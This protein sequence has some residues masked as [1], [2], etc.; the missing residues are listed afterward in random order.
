MQHLTTYTSKYKIQWKSLFESYSQLLH[1]IFIFRNFMLHIN[2]IYCFQ[3]RTQ[4]F[5]KRGISWEVPNRGKFIITIIYIYLNGEQIMFINPTEG[6]FDYQN[7]SL[8]P[9]IA[10]MK[11][12]SIND[13]KHIR[14]NFILYICI[15]MN[16]YTNLIFL[17]IQMY[18]K[19]KIWIVLVLEMKR[20]I[21]IQKT[22]S[23]IIHTSYWSEV[24]KMLSGW[25]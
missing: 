15:T 24:A 25:N 5:W 16:Y 1:Y 22:S 14:S 2:I 20:V 21:L 8:D 11:G 10:F 17:T 3:W 23:W 4:R 9:P 19:I 13:L 18:V 12:R 6:R 7:P